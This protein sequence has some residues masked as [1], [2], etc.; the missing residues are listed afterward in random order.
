MNLIT[1]VTGPMAV[2]TYLFS[3]DD[4][5]CAVIDP[6]GDAPV[7]LSAAAEKGWQIEAVLLTHGHC[8]H[9]GA[10][11]T[12]QK[13][14]AKVYIHK[15]DEVMLENDKRNLSA[16]FSNTRFEHF[17]A[18]VLLSG[19][20]TLEL[21]GLTIEVVATPGH[22][23]GGVSYICEESI[24][25]GDALFAGTVGRADFPGGDMETLLVS[26]KTLLSYP[27]NYRVLPGHNEATTVGQEKRSN[28]YAL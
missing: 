9:V 20:E 22:T 2:N 7:I 13:Q 28:P 10:V 6:G 16:F 3:G 25:S 5:H 21:A 11:A 4:C 15:G 1:L 19:G 27:E 14:G 23:L 12:L 26:V 8:D 17:S 18:D 24:F